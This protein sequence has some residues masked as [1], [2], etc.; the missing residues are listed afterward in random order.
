[1]SYDTV[2]KIG[3]ARISTEDQKEALQVDAL[4]ETQCEAVYVDKVSGAKSKREELEKAKALLRADDTFV[5]WRLDRLGRSLK[6]LLDW[7]QFFE[8]KDIQFQSLQENI[9]TATPTGKLIFHFFGALA[10][11]ERDL[12]KERTHAGL[13]AARAR[14]RKGGR[15]PKL[16]ETQRATLKQ[17]YR[18]GQHS[19]SELLSLFGI[20]RRLLYHIVRGD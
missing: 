12:I 15:K 3:Y 6:D 14:G 9:D 8:S 11:F 19:I 20:S 1:M 10:E 17:L 13:A 7:M 5:V 2:M 4:W 18:A 16:D